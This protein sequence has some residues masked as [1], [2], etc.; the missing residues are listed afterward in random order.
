[1]MFLCHYSK[2]RCYFWEVHEILRLIWNFQN[3]HYF[4][5][6]PATAKSREPNGSSPTF[7]YYFSVRK[8]GLHCLWPS[9]YFCEGS[10]I[11]QW[12]WSRTRTL[13]GKWSTSRGKTAMLE[14]IYPPDASSWF[15]YRGLS[16]KLPLFL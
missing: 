11:H 7:T 2:N 4:D 5:Q 12:S 9:G 1:M 13:R 8:V 16:L 6:F 3:F 14:V 10:V 15:M